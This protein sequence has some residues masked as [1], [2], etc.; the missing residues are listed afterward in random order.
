MVLQLADSLVA[1][2]AIQTEGAAS[3][4]G[5]VDSGHSEVNDEIERVWALADIDQGGTIDAQELSGMAVCRRVVPD[6]LTTPASH[7][8]P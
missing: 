6:V 7:T 5:G 4:A 3:G 2:S 1:M 8:Q